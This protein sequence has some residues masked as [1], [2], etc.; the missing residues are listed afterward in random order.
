MI[1]ETLVH[2][3]AAEWLFIA[4]SLDG[5]TERELE[6]QLFQLFYLNDEETVILRGKGTRQDQREVSR[7]HKVYPAQD[8]AH[9]TAL[10]LSTNSPSVAVAAFPFVPGPDRES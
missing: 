7:S 6:T 4:T 1:N 5:R 10:S 2:R 3:L 9:T 8:A